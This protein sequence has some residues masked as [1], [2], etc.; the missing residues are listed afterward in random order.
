MNDSANIAIVHLLLSSAS[1]LYATK[2]SAFKKAQQKCHM[3]SQL[4]W[5]LKTDLC[6]W[7]QVGVSKNTSTPKIINFNRVFHYKPS[8]LGYRYFWKHPNGTGGN[9]SF[10]KQPGLNAV[11]VISALLVDILLAP[12]WCWIAAW[13]EKERRVGVFKQAIHIIHV[14]KGGVTAPPFLGLKSQM[15][16]Q[17]LIKK[18]AAPKTPIPQDFR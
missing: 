5:K 1:N 12:S 7:M 3:M 10:D 18:M 6:K 17:W 4:A 8:I 15:L 2:K 11:W 9:N 14:S 13:P 16:K